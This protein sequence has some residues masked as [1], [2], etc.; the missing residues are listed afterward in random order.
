MLE[1][2]LII[3]KLNK[4]KHLSTNLDSIPV[5]TIPTNMKLITNH[6]QLSVLIT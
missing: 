5:T 4:M 2:K 6:V 1:N 3:F